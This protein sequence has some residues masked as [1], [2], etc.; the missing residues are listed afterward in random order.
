M[1]SPNVDDQISPSNAASP[2]VHDP[3]DSP[4]IPDSSSS[5]SSSLSDTDH[6]AHRSQ[7]FKRPPRFQQKRP[8]D[9]TA[10]AEGDGTQELDDAGSQ[11]TTM[12]PFS[13]AARQKS[14]TANTRYYSSGRPQ[15]ISSQAGRTSAT[16]TKQTS[17]HS[18]V[19]TETASS[20]AS[21]A[22]ASDAPAGTQPPAKSPLSPSFNHRAAMTNVGSPRGLGL[23]GR[24]EGSEGTPSMGSS[25]SDIDGMTGSS[26]CGV[27]RDG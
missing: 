24:R 13:S 8:R 2:T 6:P 17:P 9:L 1:A 19:T 18:Q 4:E 25:F 12:L 14:D 10:F 20:M 26:W 11:G 27:R 15:Q 23:R 7:L 21:S 22:S 3:P 16:P 5:S